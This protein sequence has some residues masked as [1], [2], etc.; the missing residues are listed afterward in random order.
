[1]TAITA[2]ARALALAILMICLSASLASTAAFAQSLAKT[3]F[4]EKQRSVFQIRVIDLAS[5]NRYSI[6]SGFSIDTSGAIATNFH[7]IASYAHAP[8]KYRI[9]AVRWDGSVQALTLIAIDVIHDLAIVS[10]NSTPEP[11]LTLSTQSL[12]KGA[13]IYSMGNPMDLGMTIIEGTYNGLVENSRFQKILFSG[14]LNGG[15]SG[16]P[17]INEAGEVI[18]I[19]VSKGGEQISFLVPAEHLAKLMTEEVTLGVERDF[20]AEISAALLAEQQSFYS[21]MLAGIEANK[22]LGDL[23][24]PDNPVASLKCW[25][26]SVDEEGQQYE[27]AHQHCQSQDEIFVSDDLYI[28]DFRFDVEKIT[29]DHLNRFQFYNLLEQRFSHSSFYNSSSKE[30]TG[31]FECVDDQVVLDSGSWKISTCFRQYLKHTGLYDASMIMASLD[32][33][34]RAAVVKLAASGI[35]RENAIQLFKLFAE[36]IVWTK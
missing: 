2:A 35:S 20:Q 8:E 24:V 28:G 18:G 14:S 26:H 13:R 19:N 1:M 10:S 31:R 3:L 6:G 23:M 34:Q 27:A 21:D 7:V 4:E 36:S 5:G 17:A 16:G 11:A 29:S 33:P 15:M 25:G 22:S 30:Q 9:E 32:F 12:S